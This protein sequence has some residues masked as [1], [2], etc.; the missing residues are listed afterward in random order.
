MPEPHHRTTW[1]RLRLL[2]YSA[3]V[4]ISFGTAMS[5]RA[6]L[7]EASSVIPLQ[8]YVLLGIGGMLFFQPPVSIASLRT[9]AATLPRRRRLRTDRVGCASR[10]QCGPVSAAQYIRAQDGIAKFQQAA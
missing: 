9:R 8:F 3:L 2:V 4:L 5:Q 1:F 6:E 10:G 7:R